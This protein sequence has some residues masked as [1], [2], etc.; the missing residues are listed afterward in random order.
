MQFAAWRMRCVRDGAYDVWVEWRSHSKEEAG[1]FAGLAPD[2]WSEVERF[3]EIVKD[4]GTGGGG[5]TRMVNGWPL[6]E[7][8]EMLFMVKTPDRMLE[9]RRIAVAP[10]AAEIDNPG[11]CPPARKVAVAKATVTTPLIRTPDPRGLL[12]L[13]LDPAPGAGVRYF[14][15]ADQGGTWV[16][17]PDGRLEEFVT[18]VEPGAEL[19]W[20]VQLPPAA[21][22]R[23]WTRLRLE[24]RADAWPV[25]RG[26]RVEMHLDPTTGGIFRLRDRIADRDLLWPEGARTPAALDLKKAGEATWL[27]LSPDKIERISKVDEDHETS[28]PAT[29]ADGLTAGKADQGRAAAVWRL[30]SFA[31]E[32]GRARAV[33]DVVGQASVVIGYEVTG[34]GEI[35]LSA[36]VENLSAES[37]VIRLDF[38]VLQ[39]IRLGSD[40]MDDDELRMQSFGHLRR[41]PGID[42]LRPTKYPGDLTMPWES[43][44][45]AEGCMGVI[46][47]DPLFRNLEFISGPPVDSGSYT[48]CYDLTLRTHDQI[49]PKGGKAKRNVLLTVAEGRWHGVARRYRQ[50]TQG[51]AMRTPAYPAWLRAADGFIDVQLEE[52]RL[53]FEEIDPHVQKARRMNLD[54]IQ[55]WGQMTGWQGGCCAPYVAPTPN[56]GGAP[57]LTRSL[58]ALRAL[59]MHAGYYMLPDRIDRHHSYPHSMN[60]TALRSDYPPGTRFP[61]VKWMDQ[62][63]LVQNPDGTRGDLLP[64]AE[65]RAEHEAKVT[66]YLENPRAVAHHTDTDWIPVDL[67]DPAWVDWTTYWAVDQYARTYNADAMYLDVAATGG[68]RESFDSRKGHNGFGRYGAAKAE[69]ARVILERAR[70]A[71]RTDFGLLAEGMMD[72][73][74]QY[75]GLMVSGL[76]RNHV[77]DNDLN[78]TEAM[79]YTF[80]DRIMFDGIAN[81]GTKGKMRRMEGAFLNGNRFDIVWASAP[82][83]AMVAARQAVKPWLEDADYEHTLNL[84]A[85]VPARLFKR[86]GDEASGYLITVVNPAA[87]KLLEN[88]VMSLEIPGLPHGLPVFRLDERGRLSAVNVRHDEKRVEIPLTQDHHSLYL[89]P[90]HVSGAEQL[91]VSPER[92]ITADRLHAGLHL[93]N[94][95]RTDLNVSVQFDDA[96]DE[97]VQVAVEAGA[98]AVIDAPMSPDRF[99][100]FVISA[101][102]RWDGGEKA[103]EHVLMPLTDRL[104]Q[105][106]ANAPLVMGPSRKDPAYQHRALNLIRGRYRVKYEYHLS[107]GKSKHVGALT[108]IERGDGAVL[109]D[110]RE[111]HKVNEWTP[112]THELHLPPDGIDPQMYFYNSVSDRTL[113]IRNLRVS[114]LDD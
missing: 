51:G 20:K 72:V 50:W 74:G 2:G 17:L 107:P 52:G 111:F 6:A 79:R 26:E 37:D 48:D 85:P 27:R 73:T 97:V 34:A 21:A 38:P 31:A 23:A 89:L 76:Y 112:I 3:H 54:Y 41:A 5:W 90:L 9:I 19:Q 4:D 92:R 29:M 24:A 99:G 15:S 13:R 12:H 7:N 101:T 33:F 60:G 25:L 28:F 10:T 8:E 104:T 35:E 66:A 53:D 30:K 43:V 81:G 64:S 94:L 14:G 36:E 83:G 103:L 91:L 109:Q 110:D 98:T 57:A 67:N 75:T 62:V 82:V 55:F 69:L 18:G 46:S 45:D 108:W 106:S 63:R 40:G 70:G 113:Q 100:D 22:A 56:F 102:L 59:G 16:E 65:A 42:P 77:G 61:E 32:G 47:T 86:R 88:P 114:R 44:E 105:D 58:A 93:A 78:G 87:D 96:Q 49:P 84:R 71:G 95:G 39:A 11:A 68:V 1:I 80:P